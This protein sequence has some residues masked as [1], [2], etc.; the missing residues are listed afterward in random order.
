MQGYATLFEK[1]FDAFYAR[2]DPKN[3]AS[4]TMAHGDFRG[5]RSH[6]TLLL[7]VTLLTNLFPTFH[8]DL[9][10][11]CFPQYLKFCK[12]GPFVFVLCAAPA[13]DNLFTTEANADGW[14]AIDFQLTL[15]APIP[16]DLAYLM[17]SASVL[18]VVYDG[19]EQV[20]VGAQN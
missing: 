20:G 3:G 12:R 17:A 13:G 4:V 6:R 5:D 7:L 9:D 15:K 2:A 14:M 10:D 11:L 18:P 1:K 8:I 19:A 16:T